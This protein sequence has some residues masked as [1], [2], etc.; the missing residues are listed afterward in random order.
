MIQRINDMEQL[1]FENKTR[2][3][4]KKREG[5]LQNWILFILNEES[6][7]IFVKKKKLVLWQLRSCP[8]KLEIKRDI[9]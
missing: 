7:V 5:E 9:F 1:I 3:L 8:V 6:I 2:H 4:L